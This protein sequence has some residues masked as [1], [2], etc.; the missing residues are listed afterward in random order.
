MNIS[1][2][3]SNQLNTTVANSSTVSNADKLL[4]LNN[5]SY[6]IGPQRLL[7]HID[8]DIAVN[9]TVSLIGPNGAGKSTLVK[10][11]LGLIESTDGS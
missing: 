5:I 3:P 7:S 9:E 8:I 4:S 10:L 6:H 1:T 11:I 2:L